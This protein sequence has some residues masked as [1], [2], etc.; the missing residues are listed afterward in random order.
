MP[1]R[2]WVDLVGYQFEA[3]H[4]GA[5]SQLLADPGTGPRVA[6]ALVGESVDSVVSVQRQGKVGRAKADIRV[7]AT[8][9]GEEHV[10]GV[11]T[12]VDSQMSTDQLERTAANGDHVALLCLG[13]SAMQTCTVV[14]VIDED[15]NWAVMDLMRWSDLLRE[16]ELSPLMEQYRDAI[17]EEAAE[18]RR[19]R[20]IARGEQAPKSFTPRNEDLIAWAWLDETWK[21]IC[22]MEDPGRFRAHKDISGPIFF[23]EDSWADCASTAGGFYVDLMGTG[24]RHQIALKASGVA[25]DLRYETHRI[26]AV[27]NIPNALPP[28][29]RVVASNTFTALVWDVTECTAI[30]TALIA[31]EAR[32][33]GARA[34]AQL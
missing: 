28:A 7:L 4:D 14:P 32:E 25:A 24:G 29:R 34:A 15:R 10:I 31:L 1:P 23:W 26:I 5:I 30:E 3:V 11:E 9:H 12:K 13:A 2:S 8:F 6:S 27:M 22:S 21:A 20:A 18:H 17:V 16:V 33:T 19:A